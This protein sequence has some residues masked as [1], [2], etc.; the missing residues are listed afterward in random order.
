M[1]RRRANC[2]SAYLTRRS[3]CSG[4]SSPTDGRDPS[5]LPTIH[6]KG[7]NQAN[8]VSMLSSYYQ[9]GR[10]FARVFSDCLK[11][12]HDDESY[13]EWATCVNKEGTNVVELTPVFSIGI[14]PVHLQ[15]CAPVVDNGPDTLDAALW[16]ETNRLV[17]AAAAW[18][19]RRVMP[20]EAAALNETALAEMT[21]PELARRF[22]TLPILL[23]LRADNEMLRQLP[24]E[25]LSAKAFAGLTLVERRAIHNVLADRPLGWTEAQLSLYVERERELIAAAI[26]GPSG[27]AYDALYSVHLP[28]TYSTYAQEPRGWQHDVSE[29]EY[30]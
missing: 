24:L 27:T 12:K 16:T 17:N 23:V 15:P 25:L 11:G 29:G 6:S 13:K 3:S 22:K 18:Q 8:R 28:F 26:E 10:W 4:G 1:R 30:P 5:V 20:V 19:I 2:C 9:A 14:S 21:S 7:P